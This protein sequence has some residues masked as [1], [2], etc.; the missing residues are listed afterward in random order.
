M[1]RYHACNL[2]GA[3]VYKR[4]SANGIH[5]AL[6]AS[7][8]TQRRLHQPEL[9]AFDDDAVSGKPRALFGT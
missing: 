4:G 2:Q 9:P 7:R 8:W 6:R 5:P 1:R 3:V